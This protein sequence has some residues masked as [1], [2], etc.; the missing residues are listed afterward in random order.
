[1]IHRD[2]KPAN[3]MIT[4]ELRV[5]VTDFGIARPRDH[6]PLTATGQVMGT[7]HY[8]AP[9]LARGETASPLSDVYALGV[10][11]YECLTGWR[12]FEGD[13]QV[14]VATA[15]LQDE[16]PPL[17]ETIPAHIRSIVMSAMAKNPAKRPQGADALAEL[18]EDA[19]L[20]GLGGRSGSPEP[21][22]PPREPSDW[23]GTDPQANQSGRR[24]AALDRNSGTP[25]GGRPSAWE[26]RTQR[27]REQARRRWPTRA[28]RPART[29]ATAG[30][31]ARPR[32]SS[33]PPSRA[34]TGSSRAAT[35]SSTTTAGPG[36]TARIRNGR[37]MPAAARGTTAGTVLKRTRSRRSVPAGTTPR[38]VRPAVAEAGRGP[39]TAGA[40]RRARRVTGG[41]C[42]SRWPR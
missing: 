13:N 36:P 16:P 8:L 40:R 11:A 32:L 33:R 28:T 20:R 17:P 29:S 25:S 31:R 42:R 3:L 15:H 41:G 21:V 14:A 7:A 23:G 24:N 35:T 12:P 2:I 18:M 5:K 27:P 39:T 38:A 1:V 9:E 34:D 30:T 10:V 6:E 26:S 4:P 37:P 19:R 22:G